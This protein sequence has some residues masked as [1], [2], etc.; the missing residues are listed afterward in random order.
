MNALLHFSP[1]G[2]RVIG[3]W[4]RPFASKPAES[5]YRGTQLEHQIGQR[6]IDAQ[7]VDESWLDWCRQLSARTP[8]NAWYENR[9]FPEGT[10]A[11]QALDA[12]VAKQFSSSKQK[13]ASE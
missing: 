6:A 10:T 8:V 1:E 2:D 3:A 11:R 12:E 9:E 4:V 13:V 5:A 7:P